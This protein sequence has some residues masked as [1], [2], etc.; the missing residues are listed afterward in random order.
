MYNVLLYHESIYIITDML[1]NEFLSWVKTG[2]ALG[3]DEIH[4]LMGEMSE[5]ARRVTFRLNSSYHTPEEVRELLSEL[6]GYKVPESLRVFPPFYSDFGKNIHVGEN[7]FINACCHFQDHG[8]VTLGDGCQ[9]GHNVV[10]ATLNHGLQP[11]ERGITYP[12]PI[13]LGKNVWVGSNS[14]ILQGVT[15]GDNA[16]IA[17]GAVVTSDVEPGTIVGGVPARFIKKI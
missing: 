9:I 12:A 16:V 17:A 4:A 2:K 13:V 10:F 15:I 7:V 3:T 1:L 8:G 6:F 14:T 5:E 11:E